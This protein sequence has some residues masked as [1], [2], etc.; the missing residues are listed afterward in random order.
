MTERGFK[1]H[2]RLTRT[3]QSPN[4]TIADDSTSSPSAA[5]CTPPSLSELTAV[6]RLA[7]PPTRSATRSDASRLV[8]VPAAETPPGNTCLVVNF[9]S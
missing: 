8:D 5:D 9:R 7:K 1:S 3:P 4:S 2:L 6:R